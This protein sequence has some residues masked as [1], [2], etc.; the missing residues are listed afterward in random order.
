MSPFEGKPW[1]RSM[2]PSRIGLVGDGRYGSRTRG[3]LG[4]R[5]RWWTAESVCHRTGDASRPG[6]CAARAPTSRL[7][8]QH[9]AGRRQFQPDSL[10]V[11]EVITPERQHLV[12]PFAQAR[13]GQSSARNPI[14][15]K[16]TIIASTRRRA[17]PS[18]ASIPTPTRMVIAALDEAMAI[19]NGDVDAGAKRLSPLR[20]HAMATTSII[21]MSWP[22]RSGRG[23]ST[24]RPEHEWLMKA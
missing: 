10:L 2:F 15:R 1:S 22:G 16:P 24:M 18:S 17:L 6:Q 3:L 7:R 8:H 19:E 13:P 14:S 9:P 12:L 21:S 5:P 4:A 11:V 23:N 20:R